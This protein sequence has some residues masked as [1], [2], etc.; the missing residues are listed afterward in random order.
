MQPVLLP[1]AERLGRVALRCRGFASRWVSTPHG[2]VHAYEARG[3]GTLPPAVVLHGLG[4]GATPFAPVLERLCRDVRRV[5]APDFPGHGLSPEPCVRLTPEALF[6]SMTT[7]I[8]ALVGEP[9][10]VVGN[11]LGGAVALHYA[12]ARPDRVHALILVSPAGARATE[13][14]WRELREAFDIGS[15]AEAS[16]FLRRVYHRTPWFARLL[17]H[18]L[19]A[20]F[21]RR[22]VR[23]LLASATNDAAPLPDA[24]RSLRMP[25]LLVWGR[26]E[27]LLPETH[28]EYFTANLPDHAVIE[29][30]EGIGHCPHADAPDALARRIAAFVKEVRSVC[31]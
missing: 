27:R 15:R 3:S 4:S 1:L 12:L 14:E 23:D 21:Q 7:A 24:L 29:R 31:Q 19:P 18:E 10:I 17:A 16:A 11:S 5:V 9:A 28:L 25:I 13:Q 30:P 20:S 26:S 22:V 6:G 2:Q 8:D